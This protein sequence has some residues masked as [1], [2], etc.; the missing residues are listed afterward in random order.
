VKLVYVLA[1]VFLVSCSSPHDAP[2][3]ATRQPADAKVDARPV[4]VRPAPEVKHWGSMRLALKLGRTEA[5]VALSGVI[6]SD[7][8]FA[9]GALAGLEG[10]I[11][12]LDSV[13]YLS[14]AGDET[15]VIGSRDTHPTESATILVASE[16]AAW[17]DIRLGR[18]VEELGFDD[19]IAHHAE[20]IGLDPDQPFPFLIEGEFQEIRLH[21]IRG[22]CPIAHPEGPAPARVRRAEAGGTIVGFHARNSSGILTHH[23]ADTHAHLILDGSENIS[24]HLDAVR[25]CPG[26]LLRLPAR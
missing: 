24:G 13:A 10:E 4:S 14:R 2:R 22:S 23:T 19:A 12:I 21:V 1:S 9:V 25:L 6:A 11:T 18:E 7:D 26:N 5:R 3:E 17:T 20:A 8:V 15:T 16:I